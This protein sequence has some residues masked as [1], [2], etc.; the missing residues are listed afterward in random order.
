LIESAQES[1]NFVRT[2]GQPLFHLIETYRL[3]AHSKGDDDRDK[4]EVILHRQRDFLER[5]EKEDPRVY[6]IYLDKINEK[7]KQIVADVEA[8]EEL[9]LDQY[10]KTENVQEDYE[11]ASI[12]NEN[13]RQVEL[14]NS[15]FHD[16]M[17]MDEHAVFIGEDVL[18]PYGGAF[19]V[20]KNLS[21]SFPSKVFSTPISEAALVG[22]ANGLA[23][24]GF[25][26]YA[27][28]MFGDF[29]TLAMDQIIN[30][31]SKFHHMYHGKV[32]C[33]VVIRTPMGGGRGYGPTHSQSLE[34]FLLGIDNVKII[35]LN[36]LLHPADIYTSVHKEQG[37]VIVIENKIDYGKKVGSIEIPNYTLLK[38]NCD[39]PLIKASPCASEPSLT[40]VTYGGSSDW[41]L[42]NLNNIFFETD[43]IPEV[44]VLSKINPID[45]REIINSVNKTKRLIV[46]EEGST[47]GGIGS[48]II[49][50]VV[51]KVNFKIIAKRIGALGIPIPSV[52]SLENLVLPSAE[53]LINE[54]LKFQQR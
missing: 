54:I 4:E 22:I 40:I 38:T 7:I 39:Y 44:I 46:V 47:E 25:K 51:E 26:P 17:A 42:G 29:I 11:W 16:K 37:P 45:Y 28:I 2:E 50:S 35:A 30:H 49:S 27:E 36:T 24:A 33:P 15:F 48:E 1:I 8:E 53:R 21:A 3:N 13:K 19:K 41:V 14:L 52:K 20:A 6:K 10:Y 34:K 23:L 43:E 32:H 12:T 31:A 5:F 18:S 9:P